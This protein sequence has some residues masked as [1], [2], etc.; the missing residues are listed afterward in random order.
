MYPACGKQVPDGRHD[1]RG[2]LLHLPGHAC[3]SPHT[4]LVCWTWPDVASAMAGLQGDGAGRL[5]KSTDGGVSWT[6]KTG[7]PTNQVHE[8]AGSVMLLPAAACVELWGGGGG[9][10]VVVRRLLRGFSERCLE[11]QA[12]CG[13]LAAPPRP[14]RVGACT[15]SERNRRG[16]EGA[17]PA[18]F[19]YVLRKGTASAG[20]VTAV[21]HGRSST[22]STP[23][24][25]SDSAR[26][27][28]GRARTLPPS[29]GY[30]PSD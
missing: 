2:Y 3:R 21:P 8:L 17:L 12:S 19:S 9:V 7:L 11:W 28:P 23:A 5:W 13:G 6:Y 4:M 22:T 25:T 29:C 10:M 26:P 24:S 18:N 14:T 20:A 15:D 16:C 30:R 27:C 1:P